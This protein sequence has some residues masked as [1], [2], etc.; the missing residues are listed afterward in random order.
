MTLGSA[1]CSLNKYRHVIF[2]RTQIVYMCRM[3][4]CAET[5]WD[6][7]IVGMFVDMNAFYAVQQK[8]IKIEKK[9]SSIVYFLVLVIM[10]LYYFVC[11]ML[12]CIHKCFICLKKSYLKKCYEIVF[13]PCKCQFTITYKLRNTLEIQR[14]LAIYISTIYLHNWELFNCNIPI[15]LSKCKFFKKVAKSFCIAAFTTY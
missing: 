11:I 3:K 12:F 10:K 8:I 1:V 5:N 13:T 2:W 15:K 9:T 6:F 14:L 7:P 4:T